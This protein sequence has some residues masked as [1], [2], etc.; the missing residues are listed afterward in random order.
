M[1]SW[2]QLIDR[3][4]LFTEGHKG[5]LKSLLQEAEIEMVRNCDILE[6]THET[7]FTGSDAS[8]TLPSD[9][10][11]PIAVWVGG[12]RLKPVSENEI[13]RKTD[14]T[15]NT[16]TP[17]GYFVKE[18]RMWFDK[19]PNDKEKVRIDYYATLNENTS[20]Q[21]LLPIKQ[22]LRWDENLHRGYKYTQDKTGDTVV[23][24][25]TSA[26]EDSYDWIY[27]SI[28]PQL[29]WQPI[30]TDIATGLPT[31]VGGAK[32]CNNLVG[33]SWKVLPNY[34]LTV[35][36]ST[37]GITACTMTNTS[38]ADK[39]V[40]DP[41]SLKGE[42]GTAPETFW[43]GTIVNNEMH[44]SD[45]FITGPGSGA[46]FNFDTGATQD[47]GQNLWTMP[48]SVNI[49]VQGSNY[50]KLRVALSSDCEGL[51][52]LKVQFKR[53]YLEKSNPL[54]SN[55]QTNTTV[56]TFPLHPWLTAELG[57]YEYDYENDCIIYDIATYD[58]NANFNDDGPNVD[59]INE[60][61]W[62]AMNEAKATTVDISSNST[63]RVNAF[64]E[65][66][67]TIPGQ[68]HTSLCDYA[69]AIINAKISPDMYGAYW[70]KWLETLGQVT[71]DDADRDLPHSIREE[72]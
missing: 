4:L 44:N 24:S 43:G 66:Y 61:G 15:V 17:Y 20:L 65:Y 37:G 6:K 23:K 8:I 64:R 38:Y 50:N 19:Q 10:K 54:S 29:V 58:E 22:F 16:G 21:K 57:D 32:Y 55:S 63:M 14:H 25:P 40:H 47:P 62:N 59:E 42:T 71:N 34:H 48:S 1:K 12:C 36:S 31:D 49:Q 30:A 41:A 46:W 18:D 67:P 35:D 11:K 27:Y 28:V 53:K 60:N 52:G 33:G 13:Y 9:Y 69:I 72:V 5:T 7:T 51:K 3:C 56:P 39:F 2:E 70:G 68:Y 26:P 45:Y